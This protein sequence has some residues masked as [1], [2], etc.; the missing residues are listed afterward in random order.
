MGIIHLQSFS[1]VQEQYS[2]IKFKPNV[3]GNIKKKNW[4]TRKVEKEKP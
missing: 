3:K 2:W 1:T 4:L